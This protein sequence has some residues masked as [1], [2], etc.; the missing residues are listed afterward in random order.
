MKKFYTQPC[1]I[2]ARGNSS[3]IGHTAAE[4]TLKAPKVG[5]GPNWHNLQLQ[6][7]HVTA[8]LLLHLYRDWEVA[9]FGFGGGIGWVET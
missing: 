7:L 9:R 1:I 6:N 8:L 3:I 2:L 5:P 4:L